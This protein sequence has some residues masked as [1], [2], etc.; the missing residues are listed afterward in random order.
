MKPAV[1][2]CCL[3]VVEGL[4]VHTR[5]APVRS[6]ARVGMGEDVFTPHL[7]IQEMEAPRRLLLG[8]HVERSLELPNL[9]RSCQ[10]HA[11]LLFS[12][13]SSAPRTRAPFLLRRYP[14]SSVVWSPATPVG[15]VPEAALPSALAPPNSAPVLYVIPRAYLLV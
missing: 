4:S 5:R 13:R 14:G 11:N 12:A 6:A 15:P 9:F 2:P 8:L 1:H 10:A 7:V 3:D